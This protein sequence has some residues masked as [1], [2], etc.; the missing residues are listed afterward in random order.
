MNERMTTDEAI[1]LF[2]SLEPATAEQMIGHWRGEGVDTDHPMDG[3]LE[4]SY[5]HGKVFEGPEAVFPLVHNIPLWGRMSINPALLPMRLATVL[6]LRD[7]IGPWLVPVVAPLV[8]TW[9]PRARLRTIEFRGRAHA[10]MVYDAK[11]I[12]DVFARYDNDSVLGWMDGK[13]MDKP[14][15]FKLFRE[16]SQES[17]KGSRSE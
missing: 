1:A 14:Y 8:R 13:G 2:D 15:F 12:N 16:A 11:P 3:M 10:A 7:T 6:P 4:S 5:W 17:S 9:K